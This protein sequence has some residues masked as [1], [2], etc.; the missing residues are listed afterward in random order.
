[1]PT[2]K[3]RNITDV[4]PEQCACC[5]SRNLV[6]D[7]SDPVRH[8]V[9]DMPKVEPFTDETRLHASV[10]CD[11]GATTR[12]ELAVGTPRGNFG[13]VLVALV[14]LLT[15]VYRVGKRGV[16]QLLR[17]L[18]GVEMSLGAVSR[19]ERQVSDATAEPVEGARRW[20]QDREVAN[21]D[22][23]TWWQQAK[24]TWLWVATTTFVAV[25]FILPERS[26]E[27][28]RKVLGQFKGILGTDRYKGYWFYA[29]GRRQV[30]WAHLRREFQAMSERD[31]VTGD[32]GRELPALTRQMF[33]WWH[34]V[35]DGTLSRRRFRGLML[36]LGK[37]II[38][39]LD[40]GMAHDSALSG[41]FEDMLKHEDALWTFVRVEGV[42]PTNNAAERDVTHAVLLRRVSHETQSEVGSRFVERMLTVNASLRK[43]GRNVFEFLIDAVHAKLNHTTPPSLLPSQALADAA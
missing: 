3:L 29:M 9:T 28:A 14:G 1:V 43:Q 41:K 42:E 22:E 2:D 37:R 40:Q 20:V 19:C 4:H 30:C 35:R 18:Y 38:W 33:E 39:L 25:Y 31:G 10:C 6:A 12:A 27:C 8:Q 36:P 11:C 32:I 21:V 13:P 15:G 24:R 7:G 23:T 17:D 16:Q 5:G 26:S 34:R